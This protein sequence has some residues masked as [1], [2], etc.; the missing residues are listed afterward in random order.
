MKEDNPAASPR[1]R[2]T[3][4]QPLQPDRPGRGDERASDDAESTGDEAQAD[5]QRRQQSRDALK[6]VREGYDK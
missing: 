5:K 2:P 6:N 3:R 1:P 4:A